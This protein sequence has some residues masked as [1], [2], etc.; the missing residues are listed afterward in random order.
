MDVSAARLDFAARAVPGI[1]TLLAAGDDV[2][3][4]AVRDAFGGERPTVIFDATGNRASMCRDITLAGH[5]ATV[6]YVGLFQ[7]DVT[8]P[9][10]EFH[11]RELTLLGSRNALPDDLRHVIATLEGGRLDV[12]PW[13]THRAALS[14]VPSVFPAWTEPAT[15]VIKAIIEV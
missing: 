10:P 4:A 14:D 1:V 12:R 13:M 3:E 8:F 5:G 7:G 9:D 15:G 11:K 2:E 6:V